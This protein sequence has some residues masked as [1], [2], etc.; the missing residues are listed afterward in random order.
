MS[1]GVLEL[2]RGFSSRDCSSCL[3]FLLRLQVLSSLLKDI[4]FSLIVS[5]VLRFARAFS[6]GLEF[7]RGIGRQELGQALA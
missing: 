3:E 6:S 2:F 1:A 5:G 7:S 4:K